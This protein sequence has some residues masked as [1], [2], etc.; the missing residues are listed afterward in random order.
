[1][2]VA[3]AAVDIAIILMAVPVVQ[4]VVAMADTKAIPHL[5]EQVQSILVAVVAAAGKDAGQ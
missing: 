2:P 3:A 1:M 5:L 4:A